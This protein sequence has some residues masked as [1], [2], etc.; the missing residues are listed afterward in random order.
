MQ[1]DLISRKKYRKQ[2]ATRWSRQAELGMSGKFVPDRPGGIGIVLLTLLL[3]LCSGAEVNAQTPDQL[4]TAAKAEGS[5]VLWA[6]GPSRGYES[7]AH[8]FEQRFP[9]ITVSLTAG[10]SN[11]LNTRMEEQFRAQKIETDVAIFQ[12]I[13]DFIAWKRRG[14]L[15]NYKPEGFDRISLKSKDPDGAWVAVN[16]N[17]IF[18]GYNTEHVR[19]QE[20]P[21]SAIDFLKARFKGKLVSAYPADDD[22]TLFTFTSIVQKYGWGYMDQY[23]KQQPKFIQGHLGVARSLG[24]GE[25]FVSFD[26]TVGSTLAVQREGGKV[27]LTAPTDDFLPVFFS[28][29]AIFKDAP[30]SNAAKLFVTWLLSKQWQA[31]AEAYSSRD[32]V[33]APAALPSLSTYRLD[34]RYV[35]FLSG[36]EQLA[37]LRKRFER[38]T[39][40][41][42]NPGGVR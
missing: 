9:G 35:E 6:A 25:S 38:F 20:L 3:A 8:A 21:T 1:S 18:Y 33:P 4:Y 10:F 7:A 27:A 31:Q 19:K 37:D 30:H 24:S 13:Q 14:L 16:T 39:G 36:V 32:D 42:T 29:E 12:T 2:H 22:A 11:V 15:L 40:P 41:V 28:A 17:P 5:V 34:N 23:M 26:N